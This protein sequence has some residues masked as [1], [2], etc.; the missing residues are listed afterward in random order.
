MRLTIGMTHTLT[1][2]LKLNDNLEVPKDNSL[3]TNNMICYEE[4]RLTLCLG[5]IKK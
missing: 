4:R 5:L 3:E 2:T 1:L